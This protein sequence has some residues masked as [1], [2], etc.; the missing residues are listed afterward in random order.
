MGKN[1][2][3]DEDS[4]DFRDIPEETQ[5]D[6]RGQLMQ[7]PPAN[8]QRPSRSAPQQAAPEQVVFEGDSDLDL[9]PDG[10]PD[11]D[12]DYESVLNDARVRLEMGRLYDMIMN[13]ELFKDVDADPN[14][15]RSVQKQIRKFA[16][17]QM[18]I[19]LGMRKETS[20]VERLEIDFPFNQ[21]EIDFL[22]QLA[23]KGTKGA[24]ETSDNYV[25]EVKKVTEEIENVPKRK[26]LN[27]IGPGAA[28]RKP[29]Q[30]KLQAKPS[31][32]IERQKVERRLPP[33]FEE[34][35]KPLQKDPSQMDADELIARN[36]EA[37][38]RQR[39]KKSVKASGGLPQ[40]TVEQEEMLY[41]QRLAT[42]P[43]AAGTV[44]TIMALMNNQKKNQ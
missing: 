44:A 15:A 24:S 31:A 27:S 7:A 2:W 18:E 10:D 40:P 8:I 26:T 34:D 21:V 42:D 22:K 9:F 38:A 35:Y 41:T 5:L 33:E 23:Y 12:E 14:A 29:I 3:E 13:H 4:E 16:K 17:E 43:K 6:E 30:T 28:A 11:E 1:L 19:M 25:P 20:K 32:P 39:G 36:K 37:T